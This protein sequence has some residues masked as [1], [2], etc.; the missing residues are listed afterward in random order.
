[1][2]IFGLEA[3]SATIVSGAAC[4]TDALSNQPNATPAEYVNLEITRTGAPE[5]IGDYAKIEYL[6]RPVLVAGCG[7]LR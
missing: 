1:M 2:M 5:Q 3:A 7:Y 6:A 4:A